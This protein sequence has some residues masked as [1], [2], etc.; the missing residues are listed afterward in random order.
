MPAPP[1]DPLT[2]QPAERLP[3]LIRRLTAAN[4]S[5]G[6]AAGR[7]ALSYLEEVAASL[8]GLPD[9]GSEVPASRPPPPAPPPEPPPPLVL[10]GSTGK[11]AVGAFL[12]H[13]RLTARVDGPLVVGAFKADGV[14]EVTP[15]IVFEPALVALDPGEQT[16]IRFLVHV[17]KLAAGAD[18][19]GEVT[20]PG[21]G[22]GRL[23]LVV[24]RRGRRPTAR[25]A[26]LTKPAPNP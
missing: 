4:L 13:N 14:Q 15:E 19:R 9:A 2:S 20:A 5:L 18:Y 17:D 21:L 10:E 26:A 16:L 3:R 12:L 6:A 7:L 1:P 24:R 11:P 22:N 23:D 25:Q 8:R